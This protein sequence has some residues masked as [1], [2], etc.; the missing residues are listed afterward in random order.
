[1][2]SVRGILFGF[3]FLI[4][5][6][7]LFNSFLIAGSSAKPKGNRI[8]GIQANQG[9]G[10]DYDKI[11]IESLK[12]GS[13]TQVLSLDWNELETAPGKFD[14]N[15]NFLAIANLYYPAKKVPIHITI[16]PLHT[17]QKVVPKDLKNTSFDSP[18]MIKRFKDLLDWIS[19]QIPNVDLATLT[20]GSEVNIYMWGDQKKW[21][22]WTNF[23]SEAAPYARK[24]FPGTQI[25]CE[26]THA[27]LTGPDLE[28]V[29]E[30]H[31]HSDIIGIS[32]YPFEEKGNGVKPPKSVHADF[33]SMVS[34]VPNKPIV[35]YQIGYPTSPVLKSSE[36]KQS[37]FI[38]EVFKVWDKYSDRI[39]MLNF[40][41]M[42]ESP[43]FGVDHYTK[44]YEYD[45]PEFRAFLGSLGLKSWSGEPKP[46]WFTLKQEAKIRG[47]GY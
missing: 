3:V 36:K 38:M 14:P 25:S 30:L 29:R 23:Y 34:S 26:T 22:E 16:R 39:N 11:F 46:A 45:T 5:S 17:N 33:E 19:T 7:S 4:I 20:I 2:N 8:L 43:D 47:F 24:K 44:Y 35:F 28:R 42:H 41:W 18:E 12:A 9:K 1:M 13:E 31:K 6:F 37:E 10:T 15:P 32:Y 27:A 40:Q 21:E